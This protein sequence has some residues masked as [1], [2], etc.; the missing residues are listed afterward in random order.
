[1]KNLIKPKYWRLIIVMGALFCNTAY[2]QNVPV[3]VTVPTG[4]NP[5]T[6]PG[7]FTTGI[8]LNHTSTWTPAVVVYDA[9]MAYTPAWVQKTISYTNGFGAPVQT[10]VK[11]VGNDIV[12]MYDN[13]PLLDKPTFLP[14]ATATG[15][16]TTGFLPNGFNAQNSWYNTKFPGEGNYAHSRSVAI[17]NNGQ[18]FVANYGPGASFTGNNRGVKT[19][20]EVNLGSDMPKF[21][22]VTF[23]TEKYPQKVGTYNPGDLV[24]KKTEG[25]HGALSYEYANKMG[26]LVC[27]KVEAGAGNNSRILTTYYVYD[28]LGRMVWEI[29]PKA[30]E[31]LEGQNWPAL[32]LAIGTYDGLCFGTEYNNKGQVVFTRKPGKGVDDLVYDNKGRLVLSR[33]NAQRTKNEWAFRVLDKRDRLIITGT[34]NSNQT[35]QGWQSLMDGTGSLPAG[36]LADILVNGF[37]GQYP[38]SI[39]NCD[40]TGYSYYDSYSFD[41]SFPYARSF[42]TAYSNRYGASLYSVTPEPYLFVKGKL[43]ASKVKVMNGA[44]TP[45]WI[46]S[47]YFYDQKGRP[48]Q[49]HTLNAFNATQWDINTVQYNVNGSVNLVVTDHYGPQGSVK[50]NTLIAIRNIY[51][52][53]GQSQLISTQLQVDNQPQVVIA[54]YEYDE[55]MRVKKKSIGQ[56][57]EKQAYTYNL[58]GQITGINPEYVTDNFYPDATFGCKIAYDRGFSKQRYDNAI[59]GI[60]WRGAGSLASMQAY[61]YDYDKAG[62]LISAD[63]NTR[64]QFIH[65]DIWNKTRTDYSVSN[66]TYDANGNLITMKQ[67]GVHPDYSNPFDMDNL[68]YFYKP[69]S[70]MLDRIE[71]TE[72][73]RSL[74]DFVNRNS[75]ST[76]Y[77][78]DDNGNLTSDAN[79][80]LTEIEY[81][82]LELPVKLASASN[83]VVR[84]VYDAS[85]TLLEKTITPATGPATQYKYWGPFVYRNDTPVYV[86][87]SEGRVRFG[88]ANTDYNYDYF[89]KDHLGN[90]RSVVNYHQERID[91]YLASHEIA[92]ASSEQMIFSGLERRGPKPGGSTGDLM[93][94]EL[95]GKSEDRRIGTATMF[96]VMA[97][98]KFRASVSAYYEGGGYDP[99]MET[100]NVEKLAG[101]LLGT[102]SGGL[103]DMGQEAGGVELLNSAVNEENLTAFYNEVKQANTDPT[104][105]KAYL[106]YLVF[107]ENMALVSSQS[108]ALQ[109]GAANEG[110]WADMEMNN[111][112]VIGGNGYL[113]AYMSNEDLS[114]VVH[115]DNF[116]IAYSRGNLLEEQQYYPHGLVVNNGSNSLLANKY[117]YQGKELMK[118]MNAEIY[119]F[120]ARQYDPQIGRF[121]SIDPMDE[122]ASGYIGMGNDPANLIDPTGM[123]TNAGSGG[124]IR[125]GD[126]QDR[127]RWWEDGSWSTPGNFNPLLWDFFGINGGGGAVGGYIVSLNEIAT[128]FA[129]GQRIMVYAT[130]YE[131]NN[132]AYNITSDGVFSVSA[133]SAV[134]R[135]PKGTP[136]AQQ[137]NSEQPWYSW[138]GPIGRYLVPDFINIGL[139][140]SSIFGIGG[141]SSVELNWVMHGPEA[142]WR[143]IMTASQAIGGGYSVDATIN[144]G[145]VR[146]SG[147]AKDIVRSMVVTNTAKSGDIPTA[148]V[149]AALSAGLNAGGT[150]T[151]SYLGNGSFLYG[152]QINFGAGLSAGPIPINGS[153]GVSNTWIL[154]DFWKR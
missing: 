144:V 92:R 112:I 89:I 86:L 52:G 140:F 60:T 70:N 68:T 41:P 72:P 57:V 136:S 32:S 14:F 11:A 20:S 62:R 51:G 95:D 24:V 28:E 34:I 61:G 81:N 2:G 1:M 31:I 147:K 94:I 113:L 108:G 152:A 12:T 80:Q 44:S 121:L 63:F 59:S 47:V 84:N 56:G 35:R 122:F 77:T 39:A 16:I 117:L 9:N 66:I 110:N 76:D 106:N 50:P 43:T 53:N 73:D 127:T 154:R 79:K 36:S 100:V 10:T 146:Y 82:N 141:G 65:D 75:N 6:L 151:V 15:S 96:K 93:A 33:T 64:N 137:P 58:Q 143:P 40:I 91:I 99:E 42:T 129:K 30:V 109:V 29:T 97:G 5:I 102:L 87:H 142:N 26:Q 25:Q 119:D 85:G 145:T 38:T 101:S 134:I 8:P 67:R 4:T 123:Q 116:L 115:M 153:V 120:H 45:E 133:P 46:S 71:D 135:A 131:S 21:G 69:N 22:T 104:K 128:K 13:R 150:G 83:T 126:N 27:K 55:L 48:I 138:D 103:S 88:P 3:P 111:D 149:S 74:N 124:N 37:T 18:H 19:S 98:D 132:Y 118:E 130:D 23:F 139:G 148:W 105:P 125:Y 114:K 49:T 54:S 107:D 17:A 90:V 78:Y 7:N